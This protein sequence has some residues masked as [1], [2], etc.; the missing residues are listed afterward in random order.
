VEP[1]DVPEPTHGPSAGR[2]RPSIG[3]SPA[4]HEAGHEV[5]DLGYEG[6]PDTGPALHPERRR[7]GPSIPSTSATRRFPPTEGAGPTPSQG[8]LLGGPDLL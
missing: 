4:L 2:P 7:A 5:A 6:V 8:F 1:A 3:V